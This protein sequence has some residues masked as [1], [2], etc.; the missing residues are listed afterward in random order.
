MIKDVEDMTC[1]VRLKELSLF[2]QAKSKLRRDLL[3]A[4]MI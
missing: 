2:S 4:K 3:I 1:E